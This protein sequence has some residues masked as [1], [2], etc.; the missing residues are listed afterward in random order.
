MIATS[1]SLEDH[2]TWLVM[3]WVAGVPVKLP[4]A[5]YC[6]VSPGCW[7][8][9]LAGI[10]VNEVRLFDPPPVRFTVRVAVPVML[11]LPP[12]AIIVVVPACAESKI[13]QGATD[14]MT[15]PEDLARLISL[16][17]MCER[18]TLD[19]LGR[20]ATERLA[21]WQTHKTNLVSLVGF[22]RDRLLTRRQ[23]G[24]ALERHGKISL[25]S[26]VARQ[27]PHLFCENDIE[28]ATATLRGLL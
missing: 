6:A 22:I 11:P 24:Y 27:L 14:A 2:V 26:I 20:A 28:I 15:E 13:L 5:M 1:T 17:E 4:I 19:L 3:S 10:T 18:D 21:Y 16:M 8:I 25:E 7:R 23:N 9:W 12:V